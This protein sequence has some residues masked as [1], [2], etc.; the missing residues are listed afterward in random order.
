MSGN[1]AVKDFIL[2]YNQ[3]NDNNKKYIMAVQQ[4]LIFAQS[5]PGPFPSVKESALHEETT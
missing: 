2:K 4:A 5:Q 1:E 3:L